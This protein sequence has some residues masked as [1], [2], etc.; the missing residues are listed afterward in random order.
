MENYKKVEHKL[1]V[2]ICNRVMQDR[3]HTAEDRTS[4]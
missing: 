1:E 2:K 4:L 3:T